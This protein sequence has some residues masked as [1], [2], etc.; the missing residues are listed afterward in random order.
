MADGDI[1]SLGRPKRGKSTVDGEVRGLLVASHA[2]TSAH[3]YPTPRAS[4]LRGRGGCQHGMRRVQKMGRRLSAGLLVAMLAALSSQWPCSA[5]QL[6]LLNT[7]HVFYYEASQCLASCV[8]VCVRVC[9]RARMNM[10]CGRQPLPRWA[11]ACK[12]ALPASSA[13]TMRL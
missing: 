8:C 10:V 7:A 9:V 5:F 13:T 12:Q 2:S 3:I 4:A 1:V 11:R 6:S